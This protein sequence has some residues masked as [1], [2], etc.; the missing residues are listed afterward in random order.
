M[1]DH[2]SMFNRP[3]EPGHMVEST[4]GPMFI[5][6]GRGIGIEPID[7]GGGLAG[8]GPAALLWVAYAAFARGGMALVST[9]FAPDVIGHEYGTGIEPRSLHG[10]DAVLRRLADMAVAHW[11]LV[12]I[13]LD[14]LVSTTTS[15]AVVATWHATSRYT[16]H[17]YAVQHVLVARLDAQGRFVE[18]W[19]IYDRP[20]LDPGGACSGLIVPNE[21]AIDP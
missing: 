14:R 15:L 19:L 21:G 4:V 1:E 5:C 6:G 8:S 12:I 17:T 10:R 13:S 7:A 2:D 18:V 3:W 16:G 11:E 9:L 20:R